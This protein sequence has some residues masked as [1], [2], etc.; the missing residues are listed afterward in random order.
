MPTYRD[1]LDKLS[2][3]SS[4]QLDTEVRIIPVGFTDNDAAELLKYPTIPYALKLD[5]AA[6]DIYYYKPSDNSEDDFQEPGIVDFSEEETR[7]LGIADDPDYTLICRKGTTFLRV[8]EDKLRSAV[9]TRVG[10]L[11]TRIMQI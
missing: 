5:K 9:E 2:Q 1:I 8:S 10:N 11:D 7:E 6:S 4:E 3:M